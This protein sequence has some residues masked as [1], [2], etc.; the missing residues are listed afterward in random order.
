MQTIEP[1]ELAS[2]QKLYPVVNPNRLTASDCMRS[3]VGSKACIRDYRPAYTSPQAQLIPP[4]AAR[5]V[6]F[7]EDLMLKVRALRAGCVCYCA[8][9]GG[10]LT[11]MRSRSVAAAIVVACLLALLCQYAEERVPPGML[12][13]RTSAAPLNDSAPRTQAVQ[14]KSNSPDALPLHCNAHVRGAPG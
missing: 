12:G 13:A 5:V 11:W 3:R 1:K 4:T 7:D 8:V 14:V 10:G 9:Q 2:P 6:K